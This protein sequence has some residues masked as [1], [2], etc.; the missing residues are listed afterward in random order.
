MAG[1][2]LIDVAKLF[3]A[4]KSIAKQHVNLRSQQL[5]VYNR[6][7]TLAKAVKSQTERVTLTAEAAIALSKRFSDDLPS[8]ASAAASQTTTAATTRHESIPREETV[9][10][11]PP[12]D[13]TRDGLEQDHHYDRSGR[14][15][16]TD[17]VPKDSMHVHQEE[18][19]RRPLPDGT[20]PTTGESLENNLKGKDTFLEPPKPE[21]PKQSLAAERHEEGVREDEG[22]RP[23]AS[24][25]STIPV[26]GQPLGVTGEERVPEGV[27]MDVFRTKRVAK[28]LGG[29]PYARKDQL[30]SKVTN[31][32]LYNSA[33]STAG[34]DQNSID[35]Q[36]S[37]QSKPYTPDRPSKSD[38]PTT[39][40]EMHEFASQIAKDV[41]ATPSSVF[42]I[43]GE[44]N[45]EPTKAPYEL[46]ESK[47]PSSRFGRIWQ[48][49]GL[50]TSMAFGA[51]G[52]SLRRV[53]GSAAAT[54]G[55]IMLSPGN[56]ELLVAKLSRMRGAALKMGQM[57]SIQDKV[58]PPAISEVLQRVQD[59]A[60]YMPAS[61]RNK[62]LKANLGA[63]WR[64][65]FESFDDVPVAAASIGQVHR[66]VLCS[67][68]QTVAVKVQYPGV[69]S[70]IDSDL[71]NLSILLTASRLL[72]K[73]LYLDKTIAN[74]RTELGWECNYIREAECQTRFRDLLADD[75]DVFTVPKVVP[76]ASGPEVLTAEFMSGIGVTKLPSLRQDQRDWIGTQI[77]RLCLRE[78]V[79]F[80]FMQT[81]PNWTNFLYNQEQ[82]K[83]ELLDF[84]ASRDYP[85][86]FVGPYIRVLIAASQ[87]DR[88]VIRDLSIELGYLT[89]SESQAMLD[90]HVQSVLTLAEPFRADGPE[91]YDFRDQTITDRVRDL[92]PVMVNERLAPPP[93][94][95]YSLHRKLSGAF[96]LCARLGSRVP[97]R[98]LFA[99]AVETYKSGGKMK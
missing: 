13:D 81:D 45:I 35:V 85:D 6:T 78:I 62:V 28:M 40:K 46:R 51:V 87:G 69:S 66:A 32:T 50:G 92:I 95:T 29:N 97:C 33:K 75:T 63:D 84:G 37:E 53:T 8:Y 56:M 26:P 27:N 20:I 73:G 79:E 99:S 11:E 64:D 18:A 55:S 89:G 91:I 77:L 4:S 68:K 67:T 1:R 49:A 38:Q 15:T 12:R 60:D 47:V 88:D 70:S 39:E 65:L 2:R 17:S 96:L 5:D 9:E 98:Q 42:E 94:E 80:K 14:N 93:E 22:I 30:D 19:K 16:Q 59:S 10:G 34:H 74:A 24:E 90:A 23:A 25:A 72:P 41:E 52:E 31:G 3:N 82:H 7:S 83:I 54:G 48:Y 86:E 44:M 61:Q 71:N 58:L 43:T 36:S 76:E 21:L 57:I